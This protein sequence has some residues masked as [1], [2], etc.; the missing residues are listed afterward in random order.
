MSSDEGNTLEPIVPQK[1]R[2]IQ[3]ACDICRQ[4]RSKCDG[5]RSVN[6][7]CSYCIENGT[8]CIYSGAPITTKRQSYTEVLEARLAQTE[9][10]LRK[11]TAEKERNTSSSS[12]DAPTTGEW[13]KNS[14]ILQHP[15]TASSSN[16]TSP[17]SNSPS[18]QAAIDDAPIKMAAMLLRNL[19]DREGAE[20][21]ESVTM[22]LM[23]RIQGM[24]I[25]THG[26]SFLG[27]SSGALL[28]K[29]ALELKEEYTSST[30]AASAAAAA[31]YSSDIETQEK[32]GGWK[33]RRKEYWTATPWQ[34]HPSR[35]RYTFPPAPLLASLTSLYFD[36]SNAF[37]PLLHRPSFELA[38]A[39]NLHLRDEKMGAIVLGVCAVASR[40][41]NDPRV[42]DPAKPLDCGWPFFHQ[43]STDLE[44]LYTSPGIW[45]LQRCCLAIQFL[46]GTAPQAN[47][48]LVGVGIRMAQEVGAH[49]RQAAPHTPAKELWRRAFWTLVSYDRLISCALGRPCAMGYED[50]DVQLPTECDDR[51]WESSD[52][53]KM[54]RQPE[55]Q[56]SRVAF[57][58]AYLRLSNILA[59]ALHLLYSTNKTRDLVP[60]NDTSW[61][62]TLVAE[63]DS[64]LNKWV[65]EIPPHLD[66]EKHRK[67]GTDYLFFKQSALLSCT[68]YQVQMTIHRPFIPM[69]RKAPT[70][71]P[72]HSICTNAARGSAAIADLWCKRVNDPPTIALL[73][74]LTTAGIIL[75]LNVWS[76]KRT[77][78]APHMNTTIKEVH[79]CMQAISVFEPRWQMAGI[80]WD[81]L[82]ELANVGEI[83]LPAI[84]ATRA[85]H[86]TNTRKRTLEIDSDDGNGNDTPDANAGAD[87]IMRQQQS[88]IN[89][90][91][92]DPD[93]LL[94]LRQDTHPQDDEFAWLGALNPDA[95]YMASLPMYGA[96]LGRVP[97]FPP[98]PEP[99]WILPA[100]STNSIPTAGPNPHPNS[101]PTPTPIPAAAMQG[102]QAPA[103]QQPNAFTW[104]PSF[105]PIQ[106]LDA[107]VS[108]QQQEEQYLSTPH[109]PSQAGSAQGQTAEDVLKLFEND[110]MALLKNAPTGLGADDW[111]AYFSIMNGLDREAGSS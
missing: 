7:K 109:P 57:F 103:A 62:A 71:L 92:V 20:D 95:A 50:F 48:T 88:G 8:E 85:A 72:S 89:A 4:K 105:Q 15:K 87:I 83:P 101:T 17:S 22:E 94:L 55:G 111:S 24:K 97:V 2:R 28:V 12:P 78:L 106:P 34:T 61:E 36:H 46:E 64:A 19:N 56:P 76:A 52:P 18:S 5:L 31:P 91:T 37:T 63:L 11:L 33:N 75:L 26:E 60:T 81:I 79:K 98:P 90:T 44:C 100:N 73:T 68:Y 65:D 69:M 16:N 10:L 80:F 70:T 6:R 1:K 96:D 102:T 23:K 74:T 3:R 21:D 32:Q 110:A 30:S 86:P 104:W 99:E 49:R 38:L 66:W 53:E 47:W 58:N 45:D 39:D 108:H 35:P 67:G 40:F 107:N 93:A 77:G 27:K 41:S 51:Y 54:F 9:K 29:T 82:N 25:S 13:S 14:P 59:F 84:P 43:L 42:F